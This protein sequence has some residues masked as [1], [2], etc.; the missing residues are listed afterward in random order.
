MSPVSD[1]ATICIVN[2]GPRERRRRMIFGAVLLVAGVGALALLVRF[3]VDRYYRLL[4]F[5]PFW[6]G[7]MGVLQAREK[8]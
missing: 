8:T 7:A 6:A 3:Q 2:I 5:L 4:V 1:T